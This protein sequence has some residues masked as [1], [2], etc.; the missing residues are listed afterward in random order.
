MLSDNLEKET[1]NS[2]EQRHALNIALEHHIECVP[3]VMYLLDHIK[4][5]FEHSSAY[6]SYIE[7]G[8]VIRCDGMSQKHRDV[9]DI[10]VTF[11]SF[12]YFDIGYGSSPKAPRDKSL[13]LVRPLFQQHY[14]KEFTRDRDE[15]QQFRG[16]QK[17]ER[18]HTYLQVPQFW[19][20]ILNS[21]TMITC[22]SAPLAE[23]FPDVI[24]VVSED[25]LLS[26]RQYLIHVTDL[27]KRVTF[28]S[29]EQCGTYLKLERT[30]QKECL[31]KN[32]ENVT[33]CLLYLGSTE[34]TIEPGLWPAL[35][36]GTST[37]ILYI[38]IGRKDDNASATAKDGK[39][40]PI[41][42]PDRL[43]MIEYSSLDSDDE[44]TKPQRSSSYSAGVQAR[45]QSE[46]YIFNQ[47]DT[48]GDTSS[49][50][51]DGETP[52]IFRRPK[53]VESSD[54]EA[55]PNGTSPIS[56]S[57]EDSEASEASDISHLW[58]LPLSTGDSSR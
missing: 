37:A 23:L 58:Y 4:T 52:K 25:N 44:Y 50:V 47:N 45:L 55:G 42:A 39:T 57:G 51:F 2:R 20:L 13:H 3:V 31:E 12:P 21:T 1:T 43:K 18:V 26:N 9:S 49:I 30:I 10:S 38:K 34:T 7:P 32:R 19:A 36:V 27:H 48:L 22:G 33:D 29:P 16:F 40:Q 35:L 11:L 24:H 14:P 46:G 15:N 56:E 54:K 28:L 8:T 17:D 41:K 53:M 6:G 5:Q